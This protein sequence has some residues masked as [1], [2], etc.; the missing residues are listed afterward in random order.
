LYKKGAGG[1]IKKTEK[2][3]MTLESG[4]ITYYKTEKDQSSNT[5]GKVID[6]SGG[7]ATKGKEEKGKYWINV[8]GGNKKQKREIA[9]EDKENWE[10]WINA[11]NDHAKGGG[12]TE[13]KKE[14]KVEEKKKRQKL[15]KKEEKKG[16]EK[17]R[18]K[19][20]KK[21]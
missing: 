18:E 14:T 4:K 16:G 20:G 3:F 21:G 8:V 12:K 9:A 7:T 2:R 11:I 17:G 10:K 5:K 13:E 6:V 1:I 15:K 19:G